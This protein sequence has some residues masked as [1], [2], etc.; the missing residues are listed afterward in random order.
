MSERGTTRLVLVLLVALLAFPQ[1]T[2]AAPNIV[3]NGTPESC[4]E[5][6]LQDA[7][8]AARAHGGGKIRFDCGP[9]PVSI[10]LSEA[11][12]EDPQTGAPVALMIPNNTT[13]DGGGLITLA[14]SLNG[15]LMSV[16]HDT[17][18]AL[19]NLSITNLSRFA[20]IVTAGALTIED[21]TVSNC[22]RGILNLGALT[23]KGSTFIASLSMSN[24]GVIDNQGTLSVRDSAF[25]GGVPWS[26]SF[27]GAINN[28]GTLTVKHSTFSGYF[29]GISRGVITNSG[30][31]TVMDSSFA[32]NRS[33]TGTA[34]Y[35]SGTLTVKQSTFT[36]NF[37]YF[38][39][40]AMINYGGTITIRDSVFSG[41]GT[42]GFNGAIETHGVATIDN[43]T[44]T[45]N[46]ADVGG[47]AIGSGGTLTVKH[48]TFTGN[49]TDSSG[50]AINSWGTLTVKDSTISGNNAA[51]GGGIAYSS[52]DTDGTL[53]IRNS[54]ITN[55]TAVSQ[56]GGI[57][58][59]CG[60]IMDLKSTSVT[61][62]T[63]DNIF[64]AP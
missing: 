51:I 45:D 22:Y 29:I 5:G 35:N 20:P 17:T 28:K 60:A 57:Y 59:C 8:S 34:I 16:D 12:G 40:G 41:N 62:N 47:G 32:N 21:S 24:G 56:G 42:G 43:T 9:D 54:T 37:A 27:L 36:D 11:V 58:A 49:S 26:F 48:S 1:S 46:K 19:R 33:D 23:V 44:F 61:D 14:G 18:V 4:T 7:V 64:I 53:T 55:N 39:G 2:V 50:G 38:G 3:G 13:I 15:V 63:P 52:G 31:A 30:V 6:A 25:S 10:T